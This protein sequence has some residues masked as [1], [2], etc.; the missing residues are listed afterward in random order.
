MKSIEDTIEEIEVRI[1]S[2]EDEL[3]DVT[4]ANAALYRFCLEELRSLRLWVLD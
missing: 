4:G 2:L 1:S 3:F